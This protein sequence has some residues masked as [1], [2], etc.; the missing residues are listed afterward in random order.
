MR[1]STLPLLMALVLLAALAG[2]PLEAASLNPPP[3]QLPP[4]EKPTLVATVFE[5]LITD[6]QG[7][8]QKDRLIFEDRKF[9]CALLIAAALGKIAYSEKPGA[10]IDDP[11]PWEA[12]GSDAQGDRMV[13]KGTAE[14]DAMTGTITITLAKGAPHIFTFAG[15]KSGTD[16]A[17][18]AVGK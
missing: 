16:A 4:P 13:F 8:S 17:I 15:G 9:G 6:D 7:S 5:V 12:T 10:T 14:K 1:I 3:G 18:K 11:I 2:R